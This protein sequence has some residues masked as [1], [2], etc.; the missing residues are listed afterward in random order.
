MSIKHYKHVW[1]NYPEVKGSHKLILL[2]LAEF[3]NEDS[4]E[5]WPS[6]ARLSEM[7][8]LKDRQVQVLLR[9]LKADGY[10]E[11]E[12]NYGRKNTNVYKLTMKEKVHSSAPF[13]EGEKVHSEVKKVHS[14]AEKVHSSV[15]KGALECT[16]SVIEPIENQYT[17]SEPESAEAVAEQPEAPKEE[18]LPPPPTLSAK[19]VSL[20][21]QYRALLDE[22]RT[23]KNRSAVLRKAYIFCFGE[24]ETTPTYSYLGKIA[25]QVGGAGYLAQRMWDLARDRPDGD[26]LAYIL[27]AHK[28]K[29]G[30]NG[31]NGYKPVVAGTNTQIIGELEK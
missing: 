29:N 8:G 19:V 21:K 25:T 20:D 11:I 26:I 12:T 17:K 3:A 24:D 7:T 1:A 23:T 31:Y 5:C 4:N 13:T 18:E 27:K 6:I 9:D 14:S 28:N 16:R 22:L 10:I 15:I 30:S 2:A